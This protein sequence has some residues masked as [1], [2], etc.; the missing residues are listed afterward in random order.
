M[1]KK[2]KMYSVI[3]KRRYLTNSRCF[4]NKVFFHILELHVFARLLI[5][6]REGNSPKMCFCK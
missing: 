2:L 5:L 3:I 6:Y 4:I 1:G